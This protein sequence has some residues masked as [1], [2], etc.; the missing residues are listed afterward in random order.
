MNKDLIIKGEEISL[1]FMKKEDTELI[2]SWRNKEFVRKNFIF[3]KPF[4]IEGHLS[5]FKDMIQTGKAVQFIIMENTLQKEIGSVYFRDISMEHHK[6]EYGIFIGEEDAL[7]CG[8][9]TEAAKL[10]IKYGFDE[11][12][13]HKIFLRVLEENKKAIKSYENAGFIREAFLKDDVYIQGSYRN[14]ILM[15]VLESEKI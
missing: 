13:L 3:Q 7:G 1:R 12:K 8:Y 11:L 10:D 9:G 2:V 6:A 5:W 14:I 15:A 4:T